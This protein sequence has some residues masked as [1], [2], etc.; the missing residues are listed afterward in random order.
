MGVNPTLTLTRTRTLTLTPTLTP[1]P[2]PTPTPTLIL[3]LP[4]PL[5]LTRLARLLWAYA[6]V[7]SR[8]MVV[9]GLQGRDKQ[10]VTALVPVA[11]MLNHRA[12]AQVR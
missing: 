3:P 8:G 1:T 10:R 9:S 6:V 11:D 4:L 7:E 12:T 5:T 2:T